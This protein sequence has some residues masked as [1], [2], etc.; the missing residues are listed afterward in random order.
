MIILQDPR[1]RKDIIKDVNIALS[2]LER[3]QNDGQKR[4]HRDQIKQELTNA[5]KAYM[6]AIREDPDI[7]LTQGETR[8]L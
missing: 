4:L 2:K 8:G 6:D 1:E 5:Y 7:K 3:L